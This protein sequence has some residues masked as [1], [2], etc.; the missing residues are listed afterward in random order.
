M[1]HVSREILWISPVVDAIFFCILTFICILIARLVPRLPTAR[2]IIF[3]LAFLSVYDWLTLT[4]RL[5]HWVCLLLALGVAAAFTRWV[6]KRES[7]V[8]RFWKASSP[9]IVAAWALVFIGI[10]GGAWLQERCAVAQLPPAAPGAPNVLVIVVDTLRADHLSA[11]GYPRPSSPSLDRIAQQGTLFETAISTSSW[12]LPSHVSLITGHYQ[13][14]HGVGTVQPAPWLG[15]GKNSLGGFPALGEALEKRGYRT[16]AFSANRTYFTT[17]LGFGRGFQHFE[18]YFHS[19]ADMFVRTLYGREFARIYLNRTDKSKVIRALRFLKMYSL[20]DKDSEGSAAYGG[21]Q[22]VGKKAEAVNQEAL[23]WIDRDTRHPFFAFLNYFDVH[24]PYGGPPTFAKPA[25]DKG[26]RIDEY[27]AGVKYIDDALGLLWQALEQRQLAKN[28]LLIVTS[29]HGE[30][31]GQHGLTYHG[32]ALYLEL[33][34]VPL[35]IVYPGKVPVGL[36]VA[37]PVTNAA[38]PATILDLLGAGEQKLFPCPSLAALWLSTSPPNWP[39][40]ISEVAHSTIVDKEDQRAGVPTAT[41]GAMR[42]IMTPQWQLITHERRGDQLYDWN[43]DPAESSNLVNTPAGQAIAL[44]LK[45]RLAEALQ[46][47]RPLSVES[48]KRVP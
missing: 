47:P 8:M 40:P 9:A 44:S 18:D 43:R 30:A 22:G 5:Y 33:I 4:A 42:T 10:E 2:V 38:I 1:V 32:Q 15:W 45:I 16:G 7:T 35:V 24:N 39:D 17:S 14:E 12:S 19:A 34:R 20:L 41:T 11:Y 26:S 25:W 31:L 23:Q 46:P 36:R 6:A 27:D 48:A 28:T 3:L 37:T 29:D 13:F 21:A